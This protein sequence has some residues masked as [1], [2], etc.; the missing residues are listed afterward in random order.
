ME[1]KCLGRRDDDP[2]AFK[3]RY[4][5]VAPPVHRHD[6]ARVVLDAHPG[7][8]ELILLPQPEIHLICHSADPLILIHP[9][10]RRPFILQDSSKK[11]RRCKRRMADH[12]DIPLHASAE[13]GIAHRQIAE[14]Q[15]VVRVE[16]IPVPV[17]VEK[18]PEPSAILRQEYCLKMIIFQHRRLHRFFPELSC[19]AGILPVRIGIEASPIP[20]ID[21]IILTEEKFQIILEHKPT[22]QI[23]HGRRR[24]QLCLLN[25]HVFKI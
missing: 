13:P 11:R 18:P 10:H 9:Q 20:L 21:L 23:R 3:F 25:L 12:A 2:P 8:Q 24:S 15:D 5:D 7:I 1:G 19:I 6:L 14:P 22:H 4:R 17:F 16:Q